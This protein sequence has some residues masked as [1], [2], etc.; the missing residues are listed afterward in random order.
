MFYED[1]TG[2]V[3][4]VVDQDTYSQA[5]SEAKEAGKMTLKV[6]KCQNSAQDQ[7]IKELEDLNAQLLHQQ[8]LH[9]SEINQLRA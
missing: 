6:Q 9:V 7:K 8:Q 4:E 3:Y 2:D 1:A 5:L